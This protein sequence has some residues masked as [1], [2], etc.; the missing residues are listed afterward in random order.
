MPGRADLI[1]ADRAG[2][3]PGQTVHRNETAPGHASRDGRPVGDEEALA[4]RRMDAV[5]D[6]KRMARD[7]STALKMKAHAIAA[8]LEA[9]A[10]GAEMDCVFPHAADG[11]GD[12]AVEI[13]AIEQV[14]RKAIALD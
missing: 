9:G 12:D 3:G 2:E 10:F 5:G 8:L 1:G 11:I 14:I 4:D 7:R 6:D 13:G